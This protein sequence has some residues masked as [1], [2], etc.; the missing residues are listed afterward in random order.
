MILTCCCLCH[1]GSKPEELRLTEKQR[2]KI[3]DKSNHIS[4]FL[5]YKKR[6]KETCPD[7]I[8]INS[9]GFGKE[10]ISNNE[11]AVAGKLFDFYRPQTTKEIENLIKK[12]C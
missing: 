10:V 12:C 6:L 8:Y 1:T 11:Y 7:C 5:Y 4:R 9:C 2:F 3:P